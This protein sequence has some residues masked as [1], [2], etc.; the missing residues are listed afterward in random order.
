MPFLDPN[1]PEQADNV[2][3]FDP[4]G[5]VPPDVVTQASDM[6]DVA[7][8]F[9]RGE[10]TVGA[11][12]VELGN[13]WNNYF[14]KQSGLNNPSPGY[15]PFEDGANVALID[16]D[17][18]LARAFS[19]ASTPQEAWRIRQS[20]AQERRD[21]ETMSNAGA[22]GVAAMFALGAVDPVNMLPFGAAAR[23]YKS[24]RAIGGLLEGATAGLLSSVASESILQGTQDTR[25]TEESLVNIAA[26]TVLSGALG[27]GVGL[28]QGRDAAGLAESFKRDLMDARG[29]FDPREGGG[30]AGGAQR[31]ERTTLSQETPVEAFGAEK[32]G[33]NRSPAGNPLQRLL[34]SPSVEVRRMVQKL[35]ENPLIMKGANEDVAAPIAAE[36]RIKMW[37]AN[38]SNA[39]SA[40][41]QAF[42][43]HRFGEAKFAARL[44]AGLEDVTGR[45]P[46]EKLTYEQFKARVA[47]ALRRGDEDTFGNEQVTKAARDIRRD[48]IEP[49][50]HEAI[51]AKLLPEDVE[52]KTAASYLTRVWLT[53]RIAAKRPEFEARTVRWLRSL[54]DLKERDD[55]DLHLIARDITDKLLGNNGTGLTTFSLDPNLRGATKE[56]TFLI[57]DK[58]I[59]DFLDGDVERVL[60]I[61]KRQMGA[62]VE[63]A[64]QFGRADM[65]DQISEITDAYAAVR[66]QVEASNAGDAAKEK[67]LTAL[68]RSLESDLKDIAAIRDRLRG[69]YGVPTDPQGMLVRAGR[70]IRGLN[71]MRLMGGVAPGSIPDVGSLALYHGMGRLMKDGIGPLIS[72]VK[73]FKLTARETRLAGAALD[74]VLDTRAMSWADIGEDYAR[75]S[76]FEKGLKYATDKFGIV[77]LASGWNHVVKAMA[78]SMSQTRTLEAV[79]ALT[80]GT[81]SKKEIARLHFLGIDRNMAERINTQFR[82]ANGLEEPKGKAAAT[83]PAAKSGKQD[84]GDLIEKAKAERTDE[85]FN[86]QFLDQAGKTEAEKPDSGGLRWAQTEKW[87]DREAVDAFRAAI[88]KE[89]DT[90]VI[91]PGQE[92]PL[93]MSTEWGK[94]V[95]Q[96]KSFTLSAMMRVTAA[97]LQRKDAA[98]M[99]GA[100]LMTSLGMLS[101]Y[102]K[103]KPENLASDPQTWVRE[104]VDRAGLLGWLFEAQN[105]FEKSTGYGLN[106]L[107][108]TGQ[109][110]R[111]ASRGVL[112]ALAGPS[113]GIPEDIATALTHALRGEWSDSDAKRIQRLGPFQN[114]FWFRWITNAIHQG[115]DQETGH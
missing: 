35:A 63:V 9:L 7:G 38:L 2:Q 20:I 98:A 77:N 37:D 115:D 84:L 49:L 51:A 75:Y 96:F 97:G 64:R 47:Q 5:Y 53:E 91:T 99:Q 19:N 88:V 60:R 40:L 94:T 109:A 80:K 41:D 12:G 76:G 62:D 10:T 81:A 30:G 112:A 73:Q 36:T 29:D 54:E 69:R 39:L 66:K 55:G 28:L 90:T 23:A 101:Y 56:R 95:G 70:A 26:A 34:A 111:Y 52:P 87:T 50:K 44:R 103:V 17:P 113:V 83:A 46:N 43:E 108:G 14:D 86:R 3:G 106:S 6:T 102:L 59:E 42:A 16:E 4:Q 79:E 68:Q 85:A 8:A 92:K 57:P 78:G 58:D 72:N 89:T 32:L 74:W 65:Q 11:V 114:V 100:V 107:T 61:Y 45:R 21:D 105:I 82:I 24:G 67:K 22:G 104:G 48:L 110:S 31:T 1:R 27:G 18:A 33:A 15:D 25:P 71:Y 93:W 13:Y